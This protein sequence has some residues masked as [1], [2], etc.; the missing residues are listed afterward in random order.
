MDDGPIASI[1]VEHPA[2]DTSWLP[3]SMPWWGYWLIV[4]TVAALDL[5]KPLGVTL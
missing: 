2:A 5:R 1:A 4:A 3:L